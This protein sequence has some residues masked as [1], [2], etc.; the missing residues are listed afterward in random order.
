MSAAD[1]APCYRTAMAARAPDPDMI[2]RFRR[3]L[4]ALAPPDGRIGLAVSGGPDSL[5]LLL[6]AAASCPDR[7]EAASVDHGLRRESRAE[8]EAVAAFCAAFSVPHEILVLEWDG[9][10]DANIQARAREERYRALGA[11]AAR[12]QLGWIASA[13]H[14]DDQAETLLMRLAR[15]A[16]L[17]GL[18]GMRAT[19]PLP[20][21]VGTARLIR[22]L[23][24][25]R[26]A[27]LV[28]IVA[29]AGIDA[30]DDPANRD[31]RFDRSQARALLG[32]AGWL[33]AERLAAAA[34]NLGEADEALDWTT[35]RLWAERGEEEDG[36]VLLDARALPADLQRRLLLRAI[37][38]L[39]PDADPPGPKLARLLEA[40]RAGESGTLSGLLVRPG[41]RWRI[42]PAPPRRG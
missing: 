35:E 18:A 7:I 25:W 21:G 24:G 11:W 31:P 17:S 37:R 29:G 39:R 33:D 41:A 16:G 6:L 23:L 36:Q 20:G 27:E 38:T 19:A 32:S 14:L 28:G 22:P 4:S 42:A 9:P 13:H 26:K 15:G 8:A 2:E 40:L 10:P 3:D 30:A 12:R 5:A 34:R 1:A